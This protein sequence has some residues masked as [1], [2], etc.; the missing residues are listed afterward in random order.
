MTVQAGADLLL[1][2]HHR[3]DQAETWLLQSMRRRAG[4]PGRHARRAV[5]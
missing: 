4:R 5:A 2:A 3:R 1:L